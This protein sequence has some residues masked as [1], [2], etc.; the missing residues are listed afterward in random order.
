MARIYSEIRQEKPFA[1]PEAELAVTL[2]RTG[3]VFHHGVDRAVAPFGISH[4]Q[5]NALRI[6]RGA[7]ERG[8]PTLEISRRLVSRSPNITRLL[9][10]LVDKGYARRERGTE[11]RRQAMMRITPA[12]L[13]LL[14]RADKAVDAVLAKL[15]CLGR[16]EMKLLVELLDRVREA[17]EVA[18]V[19]EGLQGERP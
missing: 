6:L 14:R 12:G 19:W 7:A 5:Y 2:L 4:E 1:R 11:D 15:G 16:K 18:T 13:E 10:K 9:D 8:H 17:V 3:D